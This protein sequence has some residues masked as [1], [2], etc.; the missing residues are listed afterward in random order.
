[1]SKKTPLPRF[2]TFHC[3][4]T[5]LSDYPPTVL[6]THDDHELFWC[7][8]GRG[9][10]FTPEN[11]FPM[12]R[13]DF[14]FFPAGQLHFANRPSDGACVGIVVNLDVERFLGEIGQGAVS[15]RVLEFLCESAWAGGNH[16]ALSP[17]GSKQVGVLL[18]E[19]LE[20]MHQRPAGFACA[21]RLKLQ[22]LFLTI[23][24]DQK[25]IAHFR[26][27]F[28]PTPTPERLVDVYRFI[29]SN[30]MNPIDVQQ[31][32][33]LACLSRSHFHA[34]FKA[35][36]GKTLVQYLTSVRL[37]AARRLLRESSI[38]IIQIAHLCGFGNLSHFYHVFA[39]QVGC[40]PARY[41]RDESM[42][43]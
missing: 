26:D 43:R 22:E 37:R 14:F 20:E 32:A 35:D 13:G 21:A 38:P 33:D 10:Q 36:T 18:E 15:E 25:L 28:R 23:L 24:R 4:S 34:A 11:A 6:H 42:H 1:M 39:R 30:Y 19:L 17:D 41:A 9:T 8:E 16:V 3:F 27:D 7:M 29:E 40:S 2:P 12:R 5:G 31:M